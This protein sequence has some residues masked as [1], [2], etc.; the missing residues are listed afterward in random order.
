MLTEEI[1]VALTLGIPSLVVA[2][3][4]LIIAY[5]T[6]R[7]A[8]AARADR[9]DVSRPPILHSNLLSYPFHAAFPAI[10]TYPFPT[11]FTHP[12]TLLPQFES[13]SE[14][15]THASTP[16]PNRHIRRLAPRYDAGAPPRRRGMT[17]SIQQQHNQTAT[18]TCICYLLSVF[19]SLTLSSLDAQFGR[20][21]RSCK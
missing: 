12:P 13:P 4:A 7:Q 1:I 5:L 9:G 11:V 17:S 6:Y 16:P 21:G 10:S 8:A 3:L 19:Q 15:P 18:C 20:A 14:E 2:M